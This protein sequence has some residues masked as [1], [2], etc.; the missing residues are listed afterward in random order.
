[1]SI[2]RFYWFGSTAEVFCTFK[3]PAS[4]LTT[5]PWRHGLSLPGPA[6]HK[7]QRGRSPT[8]LPYRLPIVNPLRSNSCDQS[9]PTL[10]VWQ[11]EYVG[12]FWLCERAVSHICFLVLF[13][14]GVFTSFFWPNTHKTVLRQQ[15]CRSLAG[16]CRV[17]TLQNEAFE[18]GLWGVALRNDAVFPTFYRRHATVVGSNCWNPR[19]LSLK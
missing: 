12:V 5:G 17:K 8:R 9:Y 18:S 1:M 7:K 13:G 16:G 6:P 15:F 11:F 2:V 19:E 3:L 4:G 10:A 14:C